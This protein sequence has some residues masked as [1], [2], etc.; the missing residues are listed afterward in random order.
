MVHFPHAFVAFMVVPS[1]LPPNSK[2]KNKK[3][4]NIVIEIKNIMYCLNRRLH[5]AEEKNG[6]LEVKAEITHDTPHRDKE[7]K[8]MKA[9]LRD[10][11]DRMRRSNICLIIVLE[12]ENREN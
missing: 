10:K 6:E 3:D 2:N 5:I 4:I 9:E 12:G 7:K 8:N 11:E 1:P